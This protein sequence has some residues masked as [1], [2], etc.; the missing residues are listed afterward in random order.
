MASNFPETWKLLPLEDCMD[1]I[2]DY[3]GKTPRKSSFG[4]PLITA[5]IVK[6]GRILEPTEFIPFEDY[7]DRMQRGIPKAG[8]IVVTTEAPLG[9]VGQLDGRK[10]SVGQRLITLR[11]KANFLDNTYLKF[12]ML[13]DFVQ[14]QLRARETGTTVVGIKQKELRKVSLVVPPLFEQRAIA[15]LLGSLDDKIEHNRC[16]NGT[17]EALVRA[18][19]KSWFVDFDPVRAKM[20]GRAPAGMDAE[21]AALFPSAFDGDVPSGWKTGSILDIAQLFSGGTP[22]TAE[23]SYWN[24]HIDWASAKDVGNAEGLFI[25]DTEKKVTQKGVDNSST[26]LLPAKTTIVTARGTV[27]AHCMLGR[28]MT[29]N[30]TNYGLKAHPGYGDYFV[31]LTLSNLVEQLKQQSYGTI[32]DTITTRTFQDTQ[33]VQPPESIAQ[34]FESLV[35]PLTESIL[36]NQQQSRTLSTLRDALLPRLMSGDVRV[37]DVEIYE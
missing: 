27:G 8:D 37:E 14:N 9:E 6:G 24:G 33:C 7:D 22:S 12:L 21:I 29:M 17:L 25:I 26:K 34:A 23:S 2:I 1:A 19:F 3:R 31:F 5:K 15:D 11:G 16:M 28:A 36:T 35:T 32:F 20:E 18:L 10:L 30:Q 13:S 4:I